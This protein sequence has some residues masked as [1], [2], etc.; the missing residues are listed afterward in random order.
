MG[1]Q[2]LAPPRY[3]TGKSIVCNTN[4]K[5]FQYYS[6]IFKY[7]YCFFEKHPIYAVPIFP[8][9]LSIQIILQYD[10]L[11]SNIMRISV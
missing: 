3:L 1:F 6:I 10:F 7:F 9:F 5:Y 4:N 11:L 2:S 8:M